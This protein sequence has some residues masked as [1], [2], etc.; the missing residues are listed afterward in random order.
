MNFVRQSEEVYYTT[1]AITTVSAQDVAFLKARAAEN[2]RRR[3]RLCAHS[4]VSDSLH[5][6][7]IV[8]MLGHYARPHKHV[9]KSE[10]FHL[11]EGRLKIFLFDDEGRHTGVIDM[12]EPGG[13]ASFFYRLASSTFHSVYVETDF[14]VFH[15]V[16]NGPFDRH[17]T[18]WAPWAPAETDS[19][20]QAAYLTALRAYDDRSVGRVWSDCTPNPTKS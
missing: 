18:I 20:G 12:S 10:S 17:D 16:T 19:T 13:G 3:V 2:P 14:V 9:A 5:E 11:I 15:E 1:S 6:M 4:Q 7:L 8:H